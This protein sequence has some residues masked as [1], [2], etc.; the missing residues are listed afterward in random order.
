MWCNLN[1]YYFLMFCMYFLI[2][3]NQKGTCWLQVGVY[4]LAQKDCFPGIQFSSLG[5][6]LNILHYIRFCSHFGPRKTDVVY[7]IWILGMKNH[8][9]CWEPDMLIGSS[10]PL[11][12]QSYSVTAPTSELWLMHPITTHLLYFT[13]LGITLL[14]WSILHHR[15]FKDIRITGFFIL[16][17][18]ALLSLWFP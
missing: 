15:S 10:L 17:G 11:L 14:T 3:V 8:N 13:T 16:T 7:C 1:G 18:I 6:T 2:Q 12:L 4:L 9:F 5:I